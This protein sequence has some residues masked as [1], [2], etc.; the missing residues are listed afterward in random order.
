MTGSTISMHLRKQYGQSATADI[1]NARNIHE[2][3]PY[4]FCINH[5]MCKALSGKSLYPLKYISFIF[6]NYEGISRYLKV[7]V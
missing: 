6:S 2:Q 3:A 5:C 1:E 4:C 7:L